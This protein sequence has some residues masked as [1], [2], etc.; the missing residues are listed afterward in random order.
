MSINEGGV[1][2]ISLLIKK[3]TTRG[4]A[5]QSLR[6]GESNATCTFARIALTQS[7][8]LFVD[9]FIQPDSRRGWD[10]WMMIVEMHVLANDATPS[11]S[12]M[13]DQDNATDLDTEN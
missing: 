9:A 7:V 12:P 1:E 11:S 10:W 4:G 2:Y 13:T 3:L 6:W 8:V 5:V